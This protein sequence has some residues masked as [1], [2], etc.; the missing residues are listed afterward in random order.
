MV[1]R[2]EWD[3]LKAYGEQDALGTY[4]LAVRLAPFFGVR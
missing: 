3:A 4:N 2:G 1:Q